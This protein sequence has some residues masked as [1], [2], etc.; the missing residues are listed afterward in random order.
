MGSLV[1]LEETIN[2]AEQAGADIESLVALQE[3]T[4]QLINQRAA[5]IQRATGVEILEPNG[6]GNGRQRRR[7]E[8]PA[9]VRVLRRI[10]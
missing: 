3:Q 2:L 10:R 1:R 9:A 6:N 4:Q 8:Q 5:L 7:N